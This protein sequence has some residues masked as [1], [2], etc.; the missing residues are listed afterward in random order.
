MHRQP[1][2]HL[3]LALLKRRALWLL[4]V[5]SC[6]VGLVARCLGGGCLGGW[7]RWEREA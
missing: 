4:E 1:V 5:F 2:A 6:R 7:C 3:R